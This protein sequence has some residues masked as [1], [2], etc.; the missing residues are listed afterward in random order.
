MHDGRHF[1]GGRRAVEEDGGMGRDESG[2][3]AEDTARERDTDDDND[4]TVHTKCNIHRLHGYGM[5][6]EMFLRYFS[7]T[8][9]I[10]SY[11]RFRYVYKKHCWWIFFFM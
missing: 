1:P 10:N 2:L 6:E 9:T 5:F 3:G 8:E 7:Y 4:E 11:A